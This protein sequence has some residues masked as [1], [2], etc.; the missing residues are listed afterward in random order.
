MN[1]L[2][3]ASCFSRSLWRRCRAA[4]PQKT[5]RAP[6]V[7][8]FRTFATPRTATASSSVRISLGAPS[9][10]SCSLTC[11]TSAPGSAFL[12]PEADDWASSGSRAR[13]VRRGLTADDP[14]R[15]WM[16][17]GR[18]HLS[19][20]TAPRTAGAPET[21]PPDPAVLSREVLR[22][23]C[24]AR[25]RRAGSR[26]GAESALAGG[27]QI[28]HDRPVRGEV[29]VGDSAE[30]GRQRGQHDDQAHGLVEDDGLQGGEAEDADEEREPAIVS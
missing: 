22:G 4:L 20:R 3:S 14:R 8:Q 5:A 21:R 24:P 10:S 1:A 7:F 28:D 26:D 13:A 6:S 11:R 9:T 30:P 18:S 25:P 19:L 2:S 23:Q 27:Q 29:A 17:A 12:E 16:R 15:R